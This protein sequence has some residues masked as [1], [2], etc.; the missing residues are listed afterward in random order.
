MF[1]KF[2]TLADEYNVHGIVRIACFAIAP[3]VYGIG[4]IRGLV[5]SVVTGIT[6]KL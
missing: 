3:I 5:E 2:N 4:W 1:N 6:E